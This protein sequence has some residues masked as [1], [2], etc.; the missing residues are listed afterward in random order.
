LDLLKSGYVLN[1]DITVIFFQKKKLKLNI[2]KNKMG[3][4]STP[5]WILKGEKKPS[6]KKKSKTFR[7]RKEGRGSRGWEC[8]SCK[9]KGKRPDE[10]ELPEDEFMKHLDKVEGK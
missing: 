3:K 1:A 2:R 4:L 10:K 9:W 7:V 5:D 8:K 6:E